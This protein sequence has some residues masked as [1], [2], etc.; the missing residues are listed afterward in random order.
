MSIKRKR[1]RNVKGYFEWQ[2]T[3]DRRQRAEQGRGREE[4]TSEVSGSEMRNFLQNQGN[5]GIPP[6]DAEIAEKG[7]F[8][9]ETR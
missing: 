8:W 7:H 9:M 2:T 6:I 1:L 4:D 3:D 5:Q